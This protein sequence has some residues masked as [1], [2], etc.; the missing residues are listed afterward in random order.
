MGFDI[1]VAAENFRCQD[2]N[3][4]EQ[5]LKINEY[6]YTTPIHPC[7]RLCLIDRTS[8]KPPC[9]VWQFMR[10]RTLLYRGHPRPPIERNPCTVTLRVL[11][12]MSHCHVT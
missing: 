2:Q 7:L 3:S 4:N 10:A 5:I 8:N 11:L 9:L 6:F 1:K 12:S